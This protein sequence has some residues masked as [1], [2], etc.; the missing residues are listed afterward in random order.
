MPTLSL[1]STPLLERIYNHLSL[2]EKFQL[3]TTS[4]FF[5]DTFH[6]YPLGDLILTIDHNLGYPKGE[7]L[8]R[9]IV[10]V[11]VSSAIVDSFYLSK[12]KCVKELNLAAVTFS[13]LTKAKAM[14]KS[15]PSSVQ[16]ITVQDE[17][18]EELFRL[19]NHLLERDYN[20]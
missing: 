15:L 2:T 20:M 18:V 16:N 6:E 11:T 1:L 12:F 14:V 10:K 7:F 17:D 4:K 3:A 19:S 13:K 5:Y 8:F 9:N